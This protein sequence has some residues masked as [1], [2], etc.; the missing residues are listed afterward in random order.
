MRGDGL[1]WS[2]LCVM[3]MR[4]DSYT[5]APFHA[6]LRT[7]HATFHLRGG[8]SPPESSVA[9][10]E[11]DGMPSEHPLEEFLRVASP[12]ATLMATAFLN[13]RKSAT[14]DAAREIIDEFL[15]EELRRLA[16]LPAAPADGTPVNQFLAEWRTFTYGAEWQAF[17]R[18]HSHRDVALA[19]N[20]WRAFGAEHDRALPLL[21]SD[22]DSW[23]QQYAPDEDRIAAAM[24]DAGVVRLDAVLSQAT[25]FE[26]R[27]YIL[28]ERD[29]A[30]VD[31]STT[32]RQGD[33][34]SRVLSPSNSGSGR[35]S[36]GE[37]TTTRWDVRLPWDA[38][39]ERAVHEM[40]AGPLGEALHALSGGDEAPLFECAAIISAE[41]AA[42]QVLHS[43]T[44]LTDGRQLFTAFVA[45][46]DIAP[47]MGPTRFLPATHQGA[48]CAS[49]HNKNARGEMELCEKAVSVSALD[50]HAGDCTLYDSRL[51]HCGGAHR[52]APP[53]TPSSER[54]LFYVSFQHTAASKRPDM[55]LIED[56]DTSILPTVAAL[57]MRLGTL[58][59][60]L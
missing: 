39:V 13:K 1:R 3:V 44:V 51:L 29:R 35:G 9:V 47:H 54:V 46:Q 50:M 33:S 60:A 52:A 16:A 17:L 24:E 59:S 43:D 6:P 8:A 31:T 45:M 42:P 34:L 21:A 37:A 22:R 41:G 4:C 19:W 14:S 36:N 38:P 15:L 32:S 26:L 53:A 20:Q 57:D 5:R 58:R 49:S 27:K 23:R 11:P 40:L 12:P 2:A 7:P 28:A 55:R 25:A 48:D 30:D 56:E 10:N 18:Q